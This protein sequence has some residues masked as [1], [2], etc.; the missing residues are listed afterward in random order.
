MSYQHAPNNPEAVLQ[1]LRTQLLTKQV[2]NHQ[3]EEKN[4]LKRNNALLL[5]T[6]RLLILFAP[7]PPRPIAQLSPHP[8][9]S[10]HALEESQSSVQLTESHRYRPVRFD[11]A[12]FLAR[13]FA[14]VVE[15]VYGELGRDRRGEEGGA[16]GR[17]GNGV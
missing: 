13:G 5:L 7:P 11:G 17:D 15:H 6:F 8:V 3:A 2:H 4:S 16:G 1:R 14:S 12:G 9:H 10:I